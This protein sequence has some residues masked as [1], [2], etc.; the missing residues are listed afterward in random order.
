MGCLRDRGNVRVRSWHH[1]TNGWE[2]HAKTQRASRRFLVLYLRPLRLY[3]RF[4][5]VFQLPQR[6]VDGAQG[7][8]PG[9]RH[10]RRSSAAGRQVRRVR[11][12][13]GSGRAPP[14]WRSRCGARPGGPADPRCPQ[15]PPR[16]RR[17]RTSR[18]PARPGRRPASRWDRRT[19][20]E[21]PRDRAHW[22]RSAPG[23]AALDRDRHGRSRPESS[24]PAGLATVTTC[25]KPQ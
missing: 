6:R 1:F 17:R 24:G 15:D 23:A 12:G 21:R 10:L 14:V 16:A 3:V 9:C 19:A 11:L 2:S 8:A 4:C 25:A 5:S 20:A 13:R 22:P 18:C 7:G